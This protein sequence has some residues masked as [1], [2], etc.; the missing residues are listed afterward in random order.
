MRRTVKS[1]HFQTFRV[2]AS[3]KRAR[4]KAAGKRARRNVA[5]KKFAGLGVACLAF[6]LVFSLVFGFTDA[7]VAAQ[8][9]PNAPAETPAEPSNVGQG[10]A[11]DESK[12]GGQ[13]ET[14][15]QSAD[16]D[17][18]QNAEGLATDAEA[19][20]A[21]PLKKKRNI[22]AFYLRTVQCTLFNTAKRSVAEV[23]A[24]ESAGR[25]CKLFPEYPWQCF[26][27]VA[28]QEH[29]ALTF[30]VSPTGRVKKIDITESS[31][32]CFD[33]FAKRATKRLSFSKSEDGF[34]NV[35]V[36]FR[37]KIEEV[38]SKKELPGPEEKPK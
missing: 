29:T 33:K 3:Y 23:M 14:V 37:Y 26:G 21:A 4:C 16:Q 17:D 19:E 24:D 36:V 8:E 34:L 35:G 28:P 11:S 20:G 13:A 32:S 10:E 6:G 2:F 9:P 30:K 22:Q 25:K 27:R 12:P 7:T 38:I 18:N 5:C 1:F 31:N 15:I